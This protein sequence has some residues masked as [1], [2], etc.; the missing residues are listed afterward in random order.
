MGRRLNTRNEHVVHTPGLSV[1]RVALGKLV[2]LFP[3]EMSA[4]VTGVPK[5]IDVFVIGVARYSGHAG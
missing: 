4:R 5:I 2:L 3:F 1:G